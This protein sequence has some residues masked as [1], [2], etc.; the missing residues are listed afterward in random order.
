MDWIG[1]GQERWVHVEL[2]L[3]VRPL[4]KLVQEAHLVS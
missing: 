4:A 3:Q 1:L 2:G